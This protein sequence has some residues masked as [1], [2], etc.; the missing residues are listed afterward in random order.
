ML[1]RSGVGAGDFL[2]A[3]RSVPWYTHIHTPALR[4]GHS[5]AGR[6]AHM[7]AIDTIVSKM[8]GDR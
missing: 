1:F 8:L 2:E 3:L 7:H 5:Q 6:V 4:H